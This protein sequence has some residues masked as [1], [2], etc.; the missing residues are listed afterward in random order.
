[1]NP[2]IKYILICIC[3]CSALIFAC[4]KSSVLVSKDDY[5]SITIDGTEYNRAADSGYLFNNQK[6]CVSNKMYVLEK[7]GQVSTT[8]FFFHMYINYFQN[9]SD[10]MN[11][12]PGEYSVTPAFIANNAPCNLGIE[13]TCDS[14]PYT[15]TSS[16]VLQTANK[17]TYTVKSISQIGETSKSFLYQVV[18]EFAVDFKDST[19]KLIPVSGKFQKTL[20]VLK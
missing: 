17:N 8:S 16:W 14:V 4:K 6:G 1:M 3:C 19:N 5:I 13:L 7:L 2:S 20:A 10:F 18:G 9:N 15:T 11:S 12:A